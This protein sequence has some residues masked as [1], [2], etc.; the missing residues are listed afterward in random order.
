MKKHFENYLK[1]LHDVDYIRILDIEK[2]DTTL[3]I[4]YYSQIPEEYMLKKTLDVW[5]VIEYFVMNTQPE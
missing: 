4:T 3:T 1:E 2:H 5:T